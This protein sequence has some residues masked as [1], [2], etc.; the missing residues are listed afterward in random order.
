M[1]PVNNSNLNVDLEELIVFLANDMSF[2]EYFSKDFNDYYETNKIEFH[3]KAAASK[4]YNA[5]MF[6]DKRTIHEVYMRRIYSVLLFALENTAANDFIKDKIKKYPPMISWTNTLKSRN[7]AKIKNAINEWSNCKNTYE[8]NIIAM[9]ILYSYQTNA[10]FTEICAPYIQLIKSFQEI[11]TMR[12]QCNY[13]SF[14]SVV[15]SI[16]LQ[17]Y[18]TLS[19]LPRKAFQEIK[20]GADF[21]KFL[22]LPVLSQETVRNHMPSY[23]SIMASEATGYNDIESAY[24]II[25]TINGCLNY[26]GISPTCYFQD[27]ALAEEDKKAISQILALSL[28]QTYQDR[29]IH[30]DFADY[31]LGAFIYM[32]AKALHIDRD[33]YFKNNSESQFYALTNSE[34]TINNLHTKIAEIES[35]LNDE[36]QE[37]EKYIELTSSLQEQLLN[38]SKEEQ[39]IKKEIIRPYEAQIDSLSKEITKLQEKITQLE[40]D[41]KELYRLRELA[42][43]LKKDYPIENIKDTFKS[44]SK[45]KKIILVGG[46]INLRNKLTERYTNISFIDGHNVN[47]DKKVLLN[48]DLVVFVT[49]NMSHSLY[50]KILPVLKD[51]NVKFDYLGRYSNLDMIEKELCYLVEKNDNVSK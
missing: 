2:I 13:N 23:I 44:I 48:A 31:T 45:N 46:H 17:D 43:D 41:A 3:N 11:F 38:S 21:L 29:N 10:E 28:G 27:L 8:Q 49:A 4:N 14:K 9:L 6:S 51:N 5:I 50:Y 19:R 18:I 1:I 36:T 26:F 22:D 16:K 7:T 24:S 42:F 20:T 35:L 37:K 34:K 40:L 32:F 47:F 25:K 39:T 12:G 15:D 30:I 33:F